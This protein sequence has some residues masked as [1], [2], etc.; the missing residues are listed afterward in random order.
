MIDSG[1][2]LE[3][4]IGSILVAVDLAR[5]IV[6]LGVG[7][8]VLLLKQGLCNKRPQHQ[9][10]MIQTII[11]SISTFRG[12]QVMIKLFKLMNSRS[13]NCLILLTAFGGFE[14]P[15]YPPAPAFMP[16]NAANMIIPGPPGD[17]FGNQYM[18]HPHMNVPPP[19]I[20]QPESQQ[21]TI[22]ETEEEKS[23]REGKLLK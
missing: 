7:D 23:K 12:L 4:G 20:Q 2:V 5:E 8:K 9:C 13:N 10:T 3:I 22:Q 14:Y 17:E 21:P 19:P 15:A 6:V 11:N 16:T 18:P 1:I